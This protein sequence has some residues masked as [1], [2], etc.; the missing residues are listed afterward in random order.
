MGAGVGGTG[1][2]GAGE[3]EGG[4]VLADS[5]PPPPPPQAASRQAHATRLNLSKDT[6]IPHDQ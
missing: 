5:E 2:G 6:T 3:P 4:G 1:F